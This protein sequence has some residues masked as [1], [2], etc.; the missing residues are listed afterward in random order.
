MTILM[1]L[2]TLNKISNTEKDINVNCLC[3]KCL[4]K[5]V[6][7][8]II[9]NYM[10][11]YFRR[12]YLISTRNINYKPLPNDQQVAI[13]YRFHLLFAADTVYYF[14]PRMMLRKLL[15]LFRKKSHWTKTILTWKQTFFGLY[16]IKQ[17]LIF[18]FW[19]S[20]NDIL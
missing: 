10:V 3:V 11:Y 7:L 18:N 14:W 1:K 8:M 16:F 15:P 20:I 4:F 17:A 12:L 13:K 2:A 19:F 6:I 9:A 5:N